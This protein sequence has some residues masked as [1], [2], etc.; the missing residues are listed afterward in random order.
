[1]EEAFNDLNL[2]LFEEEKLSKNQGLWKECI[3]PPPFA[4]DDPEL[5][6]VN[7]VPLPN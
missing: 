6:G 5:I 3:E 1:M 7:H 2:H 4:A